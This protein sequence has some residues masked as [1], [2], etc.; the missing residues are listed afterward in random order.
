MSDSDLPEKR[1]MEILLV[2]DDQFVRETLQI[3]IQSFGYG[4][5]IA[6]DGFDAVEKLLKKKYD[7]VV[8]DVSMPKMDGLE[9]LAH[10]QAKHEYTDVIIITGYSDKA[11]YAEVIK[12]GAVDFLKKPFEKEELQA[13]LHRVE[14]ERNM[15]QELEELS[16]RD[17]LTGL[18]N[19]RY[20]AHK[21]E[22]E[23]GRAQ[24]Q[25]HQVYLAILDVDNFK[26][27][28]DAFGHVAGDEVLNDV[29]RILNTCTRR[30]VDFT[31]RYGGDEFAAILTQTDEEQA[32]K[33]ISRVLDFFSRKKH[34]D[35]S[36][37][38]GLVRCL[39]MESMSW[40]ENA[41]AMVHRADKALYL[42]KNSGKNQIVSNG[43]K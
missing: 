30:N 19:R 12:A 4:C 31:F 11:G 18:Y 24:R 41:E 29:G 33:V 28:N 1:N 20:F 36:L 10:I 26:G 14:R 6:F 5:D 16:L 25:G 32:V 39:F 43:E 3:L 2:E 40:A 9:L 37:S 22:E 42:A 23:V 27:Y 38:V 13:K 21:L 34:G 7:V 17:E 35:T 15:V 8:T